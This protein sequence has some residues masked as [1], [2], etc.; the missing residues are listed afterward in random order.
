MRGF[1]DLF[2]ILVIGLGLG[3]LLS[4][5]SIESNLGFGAKTIGQWT[6]W[7]QAGSRDADPYT[8]AKVATDGDVPL[9]A[10]EGIAFHGK[11]D[12]RNETLNLNCSY[13]IAGQM[14]PARLWT[15][16]AHHL[17]GRVVQ[18]SSGRPAALTSR[19]IVRKPDGSFV[20][21]IGPSLRGGNWLEISGQGPFEFIARLYDT[22][23]AG[24]ADLGSPT[25]PTISLESCG[26]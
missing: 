25:M 16:T 20:V 9:G 26:S 6:A 8:K 14:P 4:R 22:Q 23:I 18:T 15:L 21:Q 13:V 17:D 12:N 3:G 1:V 11:L 10:A 24:T 2:F 7:P 19:T 5:V